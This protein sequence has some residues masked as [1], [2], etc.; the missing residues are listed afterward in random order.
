MFV[1]V[2]SI[3]STDLLSLPACVS[4]Q[5]LAYTMYCAM[6]RA[7][8][9]GLYRL[10]AHRPFTAF[11]TATASIQRS[12]GIFLLA[13][14]PTKT[15]DLLVFVGYQRPDEPGLIPSARRGTRES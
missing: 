10:S 9:N 2:L 3:L 1:R 7:L 12:L 8:P 11:P 5:V 6:I 13:P 15:K 14:P 4:A